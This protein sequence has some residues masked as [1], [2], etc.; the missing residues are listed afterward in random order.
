MSRSR[1]LTPNGPRH[2]GKPLSG[3]PAGPRFDDVAHE[4]GFSEVGPHE[5][6]SVDD[7]RVVLFDANGNPL[8][9]RA[10]F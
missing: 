3:I 4:K 9:R 10:G 7:Q 2:P 8:T 5:T 1:Q 6:V